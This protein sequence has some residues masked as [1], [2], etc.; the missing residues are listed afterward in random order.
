MRALT[1]FTFVLALAFTTAGCATTA[2]YPQPG[3]PP[4]QARRPVAPTVRINRPAD[5]FF[6]ADFDVYYVPDARYEIFY[7]NGRWYFH[8]GQAWY[9][10]AGYNGPWTWISVQRLP[11]GLARLPG[12]Y[13]GSDYRARRVPY[14]YWKKVPPG[15][16]KKW[17]NTPPGQAK[18]RYPPPVLTIPRPGTLYFMPSFGIYYM[19]DSRL[20]IFF[21]GGFWYRQYEGHWYRGREYRGPW[22]ELYD[23]DLPRTFRDL[24]RDYRSRK[25]R[26]DKVP[27][28]HWKKR[29]DD[30]RDRRWDRDRDRRDD[31]DRWDDDHGRD[32]YDDD[33]D[34]DRRGDDDDK[35]RDRGRGRGKGRKGPGK[36]VPPPPPVVT[37]PPARP[38]PGPGGSDVPPA[39]NAYR[40]NQPRIMYRLPSFGVYYIP[41][42]RDDI[43]YFEGRWYTR[44]RGAW[45]VGEGF[46]GPWTGLRNRKVP[47]Q[48]QN[49]PTDFKARK[50]E[51]GTKVVPYGYWNN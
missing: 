5:M 14:G 2:Y 30:D 36:R 25:Y 21:Y 9:W 45:Y 19:P 29:R 8:Y 4:G 48:L 46:N 49:L 42:V 18:K 24:P 10:G 12:R 41:K 47:K 51:L 33:R 38:G 3:P 16:V 7:T 28:G 13:R 32:R 31:D 22:N 11:S 1:R 35:D 17:K 40:Y 43:F 50:D 6:L 37:P 39:I 44:A 27:Y 15:K 20:Q 34:G 23:R 26:A